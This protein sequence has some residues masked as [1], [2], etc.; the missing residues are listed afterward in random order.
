MGH[1]H[2]PPP[3]HLPRANAS[4]KS[5]PAHHRLA[6]STTTTG[7][8]VAP[9]RATTNHLP[10]ANASRKSGPPSPHVI[11]HH[12]PPLAIN[13]SRTCRGLTIPCVLHE[14]WVAQPPDHLTTTH[15]TSIDVR[16]AFVRLLG[17]LSIRTTL[18]SHINARGR[19]KF[20]LPVP[21]T[22]SRL[23]TARQLTCASRS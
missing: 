18:P 21:Q 16:V 3:Y 6:S 22:T 1:H 11:H 15:G 9:L 14:G 2:K 20:C 4:R 7:G 8:D 23:C 17:R 10:R 5:G 12:D 19:K 13:A